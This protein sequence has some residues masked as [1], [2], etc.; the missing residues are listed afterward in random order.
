MGSSTWNRELLTLVRNVCTKNME[1]FILGRGVK[2]NTT[3]KGM[4]SR[5][6]NITWNQMGITIW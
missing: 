4:E 6:L 3:M 5:R 1:V 2:A